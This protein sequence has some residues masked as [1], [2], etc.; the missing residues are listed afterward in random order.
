MNNHDI[1][2]HEKWLKL[3]AS[4]KRQENFEHAAL[5]VLAVLLFA[6]FCSPVFLQYVF[7][8]FLKG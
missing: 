1:I 7:G 8:I 3:L 5:C 6:A 4:N 2:N